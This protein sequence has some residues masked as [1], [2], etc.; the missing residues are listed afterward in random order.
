MTGYY[1]KLIT[2]RRFILIALLLCSLKVVAQDD[3]IALVESDSAAKTYVTGAF[4]STRVI[5]AHSVEFL[6]K[7]VLDF[8]I[9]HRFGTLESGI[10]EMFGLDD[11]SIRIGLDYGITNTLT[12]GIGRSSFNKELDFFIKKA[13]VRQSKGASSFPLSLVWVSGAVVQTREWPATATKKEFRHRLSYYH[14]LLMA[15]K[16][17]SNLSLQLTPTFV[18]RNLVG[19]TEDNNTFAVGVGGRYKI[20]KRMA[21]TADYHYVVGL[22]RDIYSNPLSLGVDIETGGHVF[23]LHFSNSTGMN[24]KAFITETIGAW[25]DAEI[26]FGFNISRV[27]NL[28]KAKNDSP[29]KW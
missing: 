22:D 27:F 13:L 26:R 1:S 20:S 3:L 12:V 21:F 23:Q 28:G 17:S 24:E 7:G 15:S 9:L 8:R 19:T 14:S 5:N 6:G 29:K 10:K 11:A 4:K 16:I 2:M 18:H 25:D